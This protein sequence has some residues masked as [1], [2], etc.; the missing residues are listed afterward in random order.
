MLTLKVKLLNKSAKLPEYIRSGDA[1]FD[2]YSIEEVRIPKGKYRIIHIGI[3]TEIPSGYFA[4]I[5]DRSGLA[6]KNGIH[7]LG[8]VIDSNYRGEWMVILSNLGEKS[9]KVEVGERVAQAQIQEV[10]KVTIK[11]VKKLSET[12]RGEKKFGSSGRK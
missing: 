11:E 1:S 9:Y 4:S 7:V 5:R 2:L 8:G 3:A 6:S 12:V 10:P